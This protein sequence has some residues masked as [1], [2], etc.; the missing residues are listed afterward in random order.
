MAESK[1][2]VSV[3]VVIHTPGLEVLLLE[4]TA[5]PGFWQSVTGSLEDA[6][7]PATAARRETL[8]ETGIE[9]NTAHFKD[10]R[11][12]N[13]YEIFPEWRHR[14]APGIEHNLEHVFSLCVPRDQT[15]V[16][17][18]DEHRASLWL[19]WREAASKVFSWSNRD[20]ILMLPRL[21]ESAGTSPLRR[22]ASNSPRQAGQ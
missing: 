3:L 4:R 12:S 1:K 17:A 20:A 18:P 11:L 10:W 14:Y 16:M 8:E 9:E 2:P 13:R 21:Q 15:I 7:E 5:H 19:P 22:A 6:E